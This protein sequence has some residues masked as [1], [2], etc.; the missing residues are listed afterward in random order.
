MF[1]YIRLC[2]CLGLCCLYIV[3]EGI[4][5]IVDVILVTITIHERDQIICMLSL[6]VRACVSASICLCYPSFFISPAFA[7]IVRVF[8]G[9]MHLCCL[10]RIPQPGQTL[11]LRMF[12]CLSY[13][14]CLYFCWY[15]L[16]FCFSNYY[17]S[18][19][20]S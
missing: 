8:F 20:K 17:F 2:I 18:G 11:C 15:Y 4:V 14:D 16:L 13:L 10:F 5:F 7:V 19:K 9:D 3:H 1:I 12:C 6:D